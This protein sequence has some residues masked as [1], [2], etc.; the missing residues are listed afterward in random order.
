MKKIYFNYTIL[1]VLFCWITKSYGNINVSLNEKNNKKPNNEIKNGKESLKYHD[2]H[3]VYKDIF[4][5]VEDVFSTNKTETESKD[6][7]IFKDIIFSV[8]MKETIQIYNQIKEKFKPLNVSSKGKKIIKKGKKSNGIFNLTSSF[9]PSNITKNNTPI[10]TVMMT[11]KKINFKYTLNTLSS[12]INNKNYSVI[13]KNNISNCFTTSFKTT[14]CMNLFSLPNNN[15][16]LLQKYKLHTCSIGKNFS[17]YITAI[18]CYLLNQRKFKI[19]FG[20]LENGIWSSFPCHN[21]NGPFLTK[22][23]IKD[24]TNKNEMEFWDRWKHIVIIRN[25]IDRFLSAF[26]H[27]CVKKNNK[28]RKKDCFN[29]NSNM[30]CFLERLYKDILKVK[31]K[32]KIINERIKN[33]F[34]PQTVLCDYIGRHQFIKYINFSTTKEIFY[35]NLINEMENTNIPDNDIFFIEKEIREKVLKH[36]T[37]GTKLRNVQQLVLFNNLYLLDLATKIYYQDFIAFNY[38]L[39]KIS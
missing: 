35:S 12:E 37:T 15:N 26:T 7:K 23:V 27:L 36:T 3:V 10:S 2:N 20:H 1:L 14:T 38:S 39:P 22:D 28:Y 4:S 30:K 24:F 5:V 25:P 34:Y 32:K 17:A 8:S 29:C 19:I 31:K 33:H 9:I 21:V 6:E 11:T 16:Y 13:S 18:F